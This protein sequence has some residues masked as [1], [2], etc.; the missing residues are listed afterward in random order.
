MFFETQ[1]TLSSQRTTPLNERLQEEAKA[2]SQSQRA[3]TVSAPT[4]RD[5]PQRSLSVQCRRHLLTD[6]F[7]AARLCGL[8]GLC[9]EK[10]TNLFWFYKISCG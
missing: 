9:V 8:S 3:G 2:S 4:C 10:S 7:T 5:V 1:S 6:S